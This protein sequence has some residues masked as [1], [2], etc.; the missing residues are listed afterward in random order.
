MNLY[1]ARLMA[2]EYSMT[3]AYMTYHDFL[4]NFTLKDLDLF[5]KSLEKSSCG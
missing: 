5:I 1:I 3:D 4:K 2:C